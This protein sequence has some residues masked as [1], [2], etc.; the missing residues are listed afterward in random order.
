MVQIRSGAHMAFYSTGIMGYSSGG[1][2]PQL[3]A[4]S[5]V[6]VRNEWS[7]SAICPYVFKHCK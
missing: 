5:G 6:D 4:S 2:R 7:Y 1:K 3:E